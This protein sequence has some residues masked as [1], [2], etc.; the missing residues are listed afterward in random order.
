MRHLS[1]PLPRSPLHAPLGDPL[2]VRVREPTLPP[3]APHSRASVVLRALRPRLPE[4][5]WVSPSDRLPPGLSPLS[6][7]RKTR[8][9][10]SEP[11][12]R[13]DRGSTRLTRPSRVTSSSRSPRLKSRC[14]AVLVA[15]R[16]LLARL[17]GPR[18]LLSKRLRPGSVRTRLV[19]NH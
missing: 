19:G 11:R 1:R 18:P 17:H 6:K 2:P 10:D 3:R 13:T 7:S 8:L 12:T 14:A 9:P 16:L 5:A 4:A 15:P